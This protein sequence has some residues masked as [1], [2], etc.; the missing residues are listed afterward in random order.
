MQSYAREPDPL[1]P[2]PRSVSSGGERK[3]LRKVHTRKIVYRVGY[4]WN[5]GGRLKELRIRHLARK[6]LKIWMQNTFGRILPHKAKSHYNTGVLKRAFAGWRDE[7][8]TSRREWSLTMRAECHH[9]YYL[10]NLAF[11]SWQMFM[12]LHREKKSKVHTAQS[13]GMMFAHTIRVY[14]QILMF[15]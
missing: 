1:R 7:W 15:C 9:R 11:Q 6:F 12:S 10:Y 5:K 3:Q 13:F 8:W 4:S 14:L 2:R